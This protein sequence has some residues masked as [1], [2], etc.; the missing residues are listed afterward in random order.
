MA[1]KN[2][3][4]DVGSCPRIQDQEILNLVDKN[5]FIRIFPNEMNTKQKKWQKLYCN[6]DAV[7]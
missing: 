6:Y 3:S 5:M 4:C 1:L 7:Q 2:Y